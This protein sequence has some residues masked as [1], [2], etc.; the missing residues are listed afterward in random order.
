MPQN[1]LTQLMP[2]QNP[3]RV[4]GGPVQGRLLQTHNAND[5]SV[6][7]VRYPTPPAWPAT[8]SKEDKVAPS[9]VQEALRI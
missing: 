7:R 2:F 8:T 5:V 1:A 4:T 6:E 3:I 9:R